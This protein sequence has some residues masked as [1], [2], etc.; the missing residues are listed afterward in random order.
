MLNIIIEID[1]VHGNSRTTS[2]ATLVEEA[3]YVLVSLSIFFSLPMPI[4][5]NA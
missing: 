3:L 1:P 2:I 5:G 4:S